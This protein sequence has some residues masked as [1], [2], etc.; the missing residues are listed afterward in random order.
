M[1]TI[2][3]DAAT[4]CLYNQWKGPQDVDTVLGCIN[5]ILACLEATACQKILSDHT[6]FTG[7]W[8][9]L[10][11]RVGGEVLTQMAA[12]GVRAFAWVHGPDLRDQLAMHQTVQLGAHLTIALFDDIATAYLWLQQR[13]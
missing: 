13:H 11:P 10:V 4:A 8:R 9:Q 2:Q 3:H 6:E 7:D 12:Q 1:L 5:H